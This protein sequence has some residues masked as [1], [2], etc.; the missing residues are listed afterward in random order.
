MSGIPGYPWSEGDPL[1]ASALNAAF[2]PISGG[3][4]TGDLGV[5]GAFNS[6]PIHMQSDFN[7]ATHT[8]GVTQGFYQQIG[9][10]GAYS[11]TNMSSINQWTVPFDILAKPGQALFHTGIYYNFGGGPFTGNRGGILVN[12]VQ[13]GAV[14]G[15]S[16]AGGIEAFHSS[17]TTNNT[18]GGT[19]AGPGAVGAIFGGN[20]YTMMQPGSLNLQGT[21][22]LEIDV[23]A[24]T[25]SVYHGSSGLIVIATAA[26]LQAARVGTSALGIGGQT[27]TIGFDVGIDVSNWGLRSGASLLRADWAADTTTF[28]MA[29]GFDLRPITFSNDIFAAAGTSITS[30]GAVRVG[31]GYLAATG[32]GASVN[33]NGAVVTAG[34]LTSSVTMTYP[35]D[36]NNYKAEDPYGG[37]WS[38]AITGSSITAIALAVPGYVQGTP[39]ANPITLTPRGRLKIFAPGTITANLTW[40]TTRNGLMIQPATGK[41]GFHGATPVAKQTGVAVTIA[42]V[43]TAL[44]NLGL[45]AP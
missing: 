30:T 24:Q 25:G 41:L 3:T 31:T 28:P 19:N 6:G 15:S 5:G 7:G 18:F 4:I 34:T 29:S 1:F 20:I 27:G 2:L 21:C 9:I 11:D 44:T 40:D 13:T 23:E 43:H 12:M 38:L 35:T 16:G 36:G 33:V 32:A 45:I 8:L 14:S 17:V 37:I 10:A 26:H 39:P 22:G 42:A